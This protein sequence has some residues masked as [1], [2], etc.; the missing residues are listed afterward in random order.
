M[1]TNSPLVAAHPVDSGNSVPIPWAQQ[2]FSNLFHLH[3]S[4]LLHV[5]IGCSVK[6]LRSFKRLCLVS[7]QLHYQQ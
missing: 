5:T 3:L 4:A 2:L 6:L 7:D 1:G